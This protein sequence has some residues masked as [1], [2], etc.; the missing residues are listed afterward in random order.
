MDENIIHVHGCECFGPL[1]HVMHYPLKG[2]GGIHQSEREDCP[3]EVVRSSNRD[4]RY[5]RREEY[6]FLLHGYLVVPLLQVYF[7]IDVRP[8]ERSQEV[9]DSGQG[10][11]IW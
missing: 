3:L 1:H 7:R 4:W 10:A 5:E 2:R 9:I 11:R 8:G 6:R